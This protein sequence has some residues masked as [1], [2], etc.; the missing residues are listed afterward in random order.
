MGVNR[1]ILLS[2]VFIIISAIIGLFVHELVGHGITGI[3]LGG[4][5]TYFSILTNSHAGEI[6]ITGLAGWRTGLML[7]MGGLSTALMSA[8]ILL[9]IDKIKNKT[10]KLFFWWLGLL[11]PLDFIMYS[12]TGALGLR[13]WIIFGGI[14]EPQRAL[15]YLGLPGWVAI[16][17]SIALLGLV[18]LYLRLS[19]KVFRSYFL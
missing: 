2:I 15:S 18:Y 16:A 7:L 1:L 3:L 5:I 14:G 11:N 9:F 13:H 12:F 17:V 19:K 4:K 8:V 10:A 6:R